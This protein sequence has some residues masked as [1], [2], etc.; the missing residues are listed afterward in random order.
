MPAPPHENQQ[1]LSSGLE[2]EPGEALYRALTESSRD[3]IKM[4]DLEGRLLSMNTS[5]Q[6]LMEIADLRRWL[7]KPWIDLWAGEHRDKVR[8]A[9]LEARQGRTGR[10]EA[11]RST[12]RGRPKWWDVIVSSINNDQGDPVQLLAVARDITDRKR[13]EDA[14]RFVAEA[15]YAVTESL[16]YEETMTNVVAIL[17]PELADWCAIDIVQDDGT[18]ELAAVRHSSQEKSELARTL[19]TKYPLD[20]KAPAGVYEVLRTGEPWTISYLSD[21][22]LRALSRDEEQYRIM[23]SLGLFSFSCVPL[24]ARGRTLGVMTVVS[25]ESERTFDDGDLPLLM[26]LGRICGLAVD[27]ARLYDASRN[28]LR[29]RRKVERKLRDL[30]ETLESRVAEKTDDLRKV[31]ESLIGEVRE[32]R[33]AERRLEEANRQ[34]KIRNRELQEFAYAASHDLQ[35][36]LRKIRTFTGLLRSDFEEALPTEGQEYLDRIE[37]AATRM[38]QLISDLLEYSRVQT[39]QRTPELTDLNQVLEEVLLDLEVPIDESRA[40]IQVDHLPRIDA[41]PSQMRQLFQ[42]LV[43]NALKFRRPGVP[44]RI[45]VTAEPVDSALRP[46]WSISVSDNGIGFEDAHAERIFTPFQRLHSRTKYSGSGIGLAI[47]R[48]IV[49]R[50]DGTISARSNPDEGATFNFTLPARQPNPEPV[51]ET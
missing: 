20:P 26:E 7:G 43:S 6:H 36:P 35:E 11:Y 34:L 44:P 21:E 33:R 24:K 5:G 1:K 14:V 17:V 31:N 3:S 15:S 19:R 9:L 30:N 39:R 29:E 10:F 42:N 27:N 50:H 47:C 2:L 18:L 45:R 16:E 46:T 22:E 41:D 23:K 4:L 38:S 51:P 37:H 25:A 8:H 13:A 28:E 32:R 48:R 40:E 12:I 49:E